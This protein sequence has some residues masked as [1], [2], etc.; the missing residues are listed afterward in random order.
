MAGMTP[1]SVKT[2]ASR[3]RNQ[4]ELEEAIKILGVDAKEAWPEVT[5]ARNE[6]RGTTG[7]RSPDT[8]WLLLTPEIRTHVRRQLQ[9]GELLFAEQGARTGVPCFGLR[10]PSDAACALAPQIFRAY[11]RYG[12][13]V[14]QTVDEEAVKAAGYER[15]NAGTR[16]FAAGGAETSRVEGGEERTER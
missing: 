13:S 11:Q 2:A 10:P 16:G 9:E 14:E 8:P 12:E 7:G 3:V 6:Q 5:K 4:M 15:Q 1:E